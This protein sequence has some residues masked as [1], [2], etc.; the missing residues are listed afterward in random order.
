MKS[1]LPQRGERIANSRVNTVLCVFPLVM[2]PNKNEKNEEKKMKKKK[3]ERVFFLFFISATTFS[4]REHK[5]RPGHW[6]L[7]RIL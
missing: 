1:F 7:T 3:K 6:L 5:G 2:S 4:S